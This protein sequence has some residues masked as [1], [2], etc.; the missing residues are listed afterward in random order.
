MLN[1]QLK[2][3]LRSF[4]AKKTF[5]VLNIL[6]LAVGIAA[7]VLIFLLIRYELGIDTFH[8]K[9]ARIYR[10]VSTETY[11]NGTVEFDGCA[12]KPLPDALRREFPQVEKSSATYRITEQF[13]IPTGEAMAE[14]Q[15]KIKDT[16]F[17]EPELFSIFDFPWIAGNPETLWEPFTAAITRSVAAS[18]FGRWQNA[19]GKTILGGDAKNAFRITGILD[20]LPANTDVPL[21]VVLSYA[22]LRT[23]WAPT[24]AD[25]KSWDNFDGNSQCFFLLA[26]G[27]RIES[28]EALLPG[29]VAKHYTPLFAGSDTRDSSFFQPLKQMHFDTR[30]YRYGS[31]GWSYKELW[32]M[33]LIGIF[34]LAVACINFINLATAQSLTRAK[35]IGVRKVLGSNRGQLFMRFIGETSL[36]VLVALILGCIL[37][38]LALP[39]LSQLLGKPIGLSVFNSPAVLLFLLGIGMLMTFLAGA[40]PGMVLSRFQPAEAFKNKINAKAAGGISLRRGLIVLQFAIA[41]LLIIGTLV[42]TRQTSYFHNLPMGFDRKAIVLVDLPYNN[43]KPDAKAAYLKNQLLQE[44]GV[45]AAS[46]CSNPASTDD[47][48]Q[49]YF[50]FGSHPHPEDFEIVYRAA[51]SDYL[52]TFH[53]DLV[54]GRY[55][56]ASDTTTT[57]VLFNETAARRL[58]F[59]NPANLIGKPVRLGGITEPQVPVVGIVRDFNNTTLKEQI[60]PMVLFA[61]ANGYRMLSIKLDPQKMTATL[62]RLQALYARVFPDHLFETTFFDDTVAAFYNAEAVSA[63]LFGLFAALAIFISCLGMYGLVAFMAVQKTKEVGIRKVLGASVQQIVYLFSREFTLLI[64]IAFLVAA[65]LGYYLMHHWLAGYYYHIRLGWDVFALSFLLS[66]LVAWLS[67]G[68]KALRAAMANPVKSLR[69]E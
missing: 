59:R 23:W 50:T 15:F 64:T 29:F 25:P 22:T 4:Q 35:E 69:S 16:Y 61:R 65:P 14:K 56:R 39:Q 41:Q 63:Q 55:P 12:P 18:W 58:G 48:G 30:F 32:A 21:K 52:R 31:A 3:L 20:D 62:P 43:G 7:S 53:L 2:I 6:G 19:I 26:K 54:A 37:A 47:E 44:P 68:Y 45:L 60:K 1:G 33:A 34:L 27:Q 9:R 8:A 57:E 46:L 42:I 67:V 28:M 11:R 10:V 38:A 24:L 17:A 40:Y 49:S 13:T 66:V 5:T 36:L 51:D